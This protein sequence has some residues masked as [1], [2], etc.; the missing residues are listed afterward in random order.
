[1][2]RPPARR[3]DRHCRS[4]VPPH[5]FQRR[6]ERRQH[7]RWK[8]SVPV[9]RLLPGTG[10]SARRADHCR[11]P[12]RLLGERFRRRSVSYGGRGGL[13]LRFGYDRSW[14]QRH[15]VWSCARAGRK[16]R[17]RRYQ[18]AGRRQGPRR[19]RCRSLPRGASTL[20]GAERS[21]QEARRCQSAHQEGGCRVGKVTRKPSKK[22][23]RGRVLSQSPR[24]GAMVPSGA[25]VKLVVGKGRKH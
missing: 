15:S 3:E 24:A 12:D 2:T 14:R 17:S 10:D 5:T 20:Q 11:R 25:K 22:A 21:R 18:R 1:M 8:R 19:L 9:V 4:F 6:R 16:D 13:G 23:Q 7:F